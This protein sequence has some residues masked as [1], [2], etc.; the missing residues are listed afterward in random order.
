[1][2]PW[3]AWPVLFLVASVLG[4]VGYHFSLRTLRVVMTITVLASAVCI[5]SYGLGHPAEK[6]GGLSDAFGRGADALGIAFFRAVPGTYGWIAIAVLLVIGY[7]QLE[8]WTLHNQ[9]RSLDTSALAGGRPDDGPGQDAGQGKDAMSDKQR[10]DRLAAELKFRLP[11]VQVRAPAI[12]PGGSRAGGLASIAEASGLAVGG[13]AGAI[14]NF[15]GMLWPG[16]RRLRVQ[17]W[18]E[19]SLDCPESDDVARVTVD[20][21]DPRTG[22][23]LATKTLTACCD[24][25]AASMVAGYVAR[26]IFA[27]DRTAP[28]WCTSAADGRDLAA[29]LVARQ[30]RDYPESLDRVTAARMQQ[31]GILEGVAFGSQ[32]AGVTRY[33]LAQLYD[34]TG[35]HVKALLLHA[36]NR[37][38]YPDFY[39]G[40]YRLAMSIE[41]LSQ[42]GRT[43]SAD[44]GPVLEHALKILHRC[45]MLT[46]DLS[47][48]GPAK[49]GRVEVQPGLQADLLDIAWDELGD[50][51]RY[52]SLPNVL[53]RSFWR[54]D[55]RG[56]LRPHRRQP[57]RQAFHDGVAAA[58]LLVAI[59]RAQVPKPAC[60]VI[61][62]PRRVQAIFQ[63]AAAITGDGSALAAALGI[64][65]VAVVRHGAPPVTR[66]LGTRHWL[67]PYRTRSWQAGY[68]LA[69]AYAAVAQALPP[70]A[71]AEQADARKSELRTL[72]DRIVSC[73]WFTVC[74]PECEMERPWDWIFNDPDFIFM[75]LSDTK[76]GDQTAKDEKAEEKEAADAKAFAA[77]R[78]FLVQQEQRDYPSV[79][80]AAACRRAGKSA[81]AGLEAGLGEA[82]GPVA[83]LVEQ[84]GRGNHLELGA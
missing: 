47:I 55:E 66:S 80:K 49:G 63:I 11:A 42:P 59:R 15:F 35:E 60:P 26:Y 74:N 78:E 72:T 50:I 82:A 68:N 31:I 39:R 22:Q 14:I 53:W 43:I 34:L 76:D 25:H 13:L 48:Y 44:E 62:R 10:H 38:Q 21:D 3:L 46:A 81:T 65:E 75:H 33:E 36:I 57:Y 52:L 30:V 54:R 1:M 58:Q 70:A 67:R 12:L 19:R 28:P 6:A 7:R 64:H 71:D 37:E 20:L 77:F 9:A 61:R 56:I 45:G 27:E 17:V 24:D 5:T 8:A 79:P 18:V 2:N 29:L 32:C 41:M 84:F 4:L 23:S 16:P 73:F 51:R 69:C 83:D 40:R